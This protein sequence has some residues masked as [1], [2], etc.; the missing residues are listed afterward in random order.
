M[1]GQ[2]T[3]G[4]GGTGIAADGANSRSSSMCSEK[5]HSSQN[6]KGGIMY[7][8]SYGLAE[9]KFR[10]CWLIFLGMKQDKISSFNVG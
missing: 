1:L 4:E 5:N 9:C 2:T 6:D 10:D 7:R 3:R 8:I